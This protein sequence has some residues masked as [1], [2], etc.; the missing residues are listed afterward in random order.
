MPG[1]Y[2]H[3]RLF[4]LYNIP[5][6]CL[7]F[8]HLFI[9]YFNVTHKTK[10]SVL[11]RSKSS[12]SHSS[13]KSAPLPSDKDSTLREGWLAVGQSLARVP[14]TQSRHMLSEAYSSVII[15]SFD[16]VS[17]SLPAKMSHLFLE[18]PRTQG[19]VATPFQQSLTAIITTRKT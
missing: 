9:V 10:G 13:S 15:F 14:I 8:K 3:A 7:Y 6:L 16:V 2:L 18:L 4:Y 11:P 19:G 12:Y 5:L 17:S 1:L